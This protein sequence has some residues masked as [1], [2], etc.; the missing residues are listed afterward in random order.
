MST[1]REPRKE[2]NPRSRRSDQSAEKKGSTQLSANRPDPKLTRCGSPHP[3]RR[4]RTKPKTQGVH[5]G[6]RPLRGHPSRASDPTE[7]RGLIRQRQ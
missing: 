3:G 2:V 5:S 6:R 1:G 7:S 4:P